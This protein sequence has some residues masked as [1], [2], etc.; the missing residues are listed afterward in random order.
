[1]V[2]AKPPKIAARP[3]SRTTEADFRGAAGRGDRAPASDR[4][5][6]GRHPGRMELA[7]ATSCAGRAAQATQSA[8]GDNAGD[9]AAGTAGSLRRR[10]GAR[11]P[12]HADPEHFGN[13]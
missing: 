6:T 7:G 2:K 13:G 8:Y 4:T 3:A 11:T 1:M 12:N 5:A 10:S 9:D